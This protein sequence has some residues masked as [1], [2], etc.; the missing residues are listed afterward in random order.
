MIAI[1]APTASPLVPSTPVAAAPA[2][3][4]S[5]RLNPSAGVPAVADQRQASS[6]LMDLIRLQIAMQQENQLFT[7]ISN[8]LKIRHET[9][10]TIIGNIR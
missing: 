9:M 10:K 2:S 7:A 3:P 4:F 6:E 5:D 1:A 8:I